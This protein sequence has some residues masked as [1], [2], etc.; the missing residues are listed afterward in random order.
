MAQYF[1]THLAKEYDEINRKITKKELRTV[2]DYMYELGFENGYI[3]ELG[4]HEE[5]YVPTFDLSE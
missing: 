5:E 1:P 2:E 3:Q 4:T